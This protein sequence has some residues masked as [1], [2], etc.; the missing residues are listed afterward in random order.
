MKKAMNIFSY[1]A[2]TFMCM[3]FLFK[4]MHWPG[5]ALAL[6]LS[7]GF[8]SFFYLPMYYIYKR[9][10]LIDWKARFTFGFGLLCFS[11]FM[12]AVLAKIMHWPG[13]GPMFVL[14]M[15]FFS[16]IFIPSYTISK[17]RHAENKSQKGM[18]IFGGIAIAFITLGILFKIMHWPGASILLV[19]GTFLIP[20]LY[21]PFFMKAHKGNSENTNEKLTKIY[22]AIASLSIVITLSLNNNEARILYT[23]SMVDEMISDANTNLEVKNSVLAA[24]FSEKATDKTSKYIQQITKVRTLSN[25]LFNYIAE[26]KSYLIM[27]TDGMSKNDA[28][29]ISLRDVDGK[30]NF[31][32]PTHILIGGDPENLREGN[33]SARELKNKIIVYR[34]DLLSMVKDTVKNKIAETIG[35]ETKDSYS[36]SY[37]QMR[38]WEENN[39]DYVTLAV[40]ITILSE[41]Q[42]NVRNAE[43]AIIKELTD[44]NFDIDN[45]EMDK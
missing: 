45:K 24:A 15:A 1:I 21:L 2:I 38:S 18:H 16:L 20:L 27:N 28:D 7:Q 19:V 6:I 30:G 14:A 12:L 22:F 32:V 36:R 26:M 34:M 10:E 42:N 29:S 33:F 9:K 8:L 4:M 43:S 39:F 44:E 37:E 13:A 31:D 41:I 40:D 11:I 5:A 23:F 25:E 17:C 35:L 3:G